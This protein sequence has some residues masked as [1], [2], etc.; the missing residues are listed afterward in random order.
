MERIRKALTVVFVLLLAACSSNSNADMDM[1]A[2]D[3]R[4]ERV[5]LESVSIS[6][7]PADDAHNED[8][9]QTKPHFTDDGS[10]F[11]QYAEKVGND[12]KEFETNGKEYVTRRIALWGLS[13][14]GGQAKGS[15]ENNACVAF[16][17]E[18]LGETGKVEYQFYEFKDYAYLIKTS[19][20]YNVPIYINDEESAK[21]S[22]P[23]A[24]DPEF[25]DPEKSV[26]TTT[27]YI[28]I[29]NQLLL[30]DRENGKLIVP[31]DTEQTM[32]FL[33]DITQRDFFINDN[34]VE[35]ILSTDGL[36]EK[37]RKLLGETAYGQVLLIM[38][39]GISFPAYNLT[40]CGS[41]SDI[42]THTYIEVELK[43]TDDGHIY[44]L[45]YG[46]E[47]KEWVFYTN[48][49]LYKYTLPE[50]MGSFLTNDRVKF[51]FKDI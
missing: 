43:I 25:F 12:L 19:T 5:S 13:T 23:E 21:A 49:V 45:G 40:Y 46:L 30:L 42:G 47:E 6:D 31:D 10:L 8:T 24:D 7:K 3:V 14:E 16:E 41:I 27:E 50:F 22:F 11:V 1:L 51:I 26:M 9:E 2:E 34:V 28:R 36:K 17:V 15:F 38:C 39:E 35:E 29:N 18:L 20:E 33:D 32:K 44:C 48:D 37:M 4:D